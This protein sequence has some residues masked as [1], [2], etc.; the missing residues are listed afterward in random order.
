MTVSP[1]RRARLNVECLEDRTVPAFLTRPGGTI[2]VNGVQQPAPGL[3]L[4]MGDLLPDGLGSLGLAQMEYVTGTGPGVPAR[5]NVFGANGVN[6]NGQGLPLVSFNPYPGIDFRGGINVAVGD[7]LGDRALEIVVTPASNAPGFVTVYNAQGVLLSAFLA[8]PAFY[9]GGLSL[10]VGNVLGGI[11]AGGFPGGNTSGQF[12]Q[13]IIVGTSRQFDFV[14]VHN[15]A[16]AVQRQFFAFGG[17]PSGVNV[18]A[19]SVDSTR[20]PGYVV[21]SGLE[22]TSSYDE[23]LVGAASIA[24]AVGV[25]SAWEGAI[26]TERLFFAFD[27]GSRTGVTLAAGGTD[28]SRGAELYV[29]LIGTSVVRVFNGETGLLFGQR[30]VYP[31]GFTGVLNMA[32]GYVFPSTY[33]PSDDDDNPPDGNSDFIIQD[34]LIVTGDGP[35]FQSPRQFIGG[36]FPALFNGAPTF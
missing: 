21:G 6:A 15:A 33:D 17:A 4:A 28:N 8:T 32:I 24:P 27:P 2:N 5:V 31:A 23:I 19:G 34:L 22:D 18:A 35:A 13:E 10:A 14:S 1:A 11:A 3:S 30:Q 20:D 7:V 16:G 9:T 25:F 36:S 29:N 12:K 26:I